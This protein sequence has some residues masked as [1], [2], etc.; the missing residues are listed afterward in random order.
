MLKA[1]IPPGIVNIIC[2]WYGKM[3][4]SVRWNNEL[5]DSFHVCSGV[6]QGSMLSP[7]LFNVFINI[8]IIKLKIS[9]MGCHIGDMFYGC[10]LYADDL[11]ILCPSVNGL[12]IMLDVCV[13]TANSLALKFNESKSHCIRFGKCCCA[14]IDPMLLGNVAIDWVQS[15][16]Y[17]GTCIVSGHKLSFDITGTKRSFYAAFN[18]IHSH[19]KSLDQIVQLTL[20]ESYCLPLLTYASAALTLS[21][22]QLNELNVCWNTVYRLI[23]KFHRWESVKCFICGLGRL[24]LIHIMQKIKVKFYHHLLTVTN[25][26]LYNLLWTYYSDSCCSD[27]V[28]HCLFLSRSAAIAECYKISV[29]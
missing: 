16:K 3:F 6:R 7:A 22:K 2:N 1:G 20:H 18:C 4:V 29:L 10:I 28:L 17:L 5:S 25:K 11:I 9:D 15:V 21:T 13:E 23:F 8:F 14:S 27:H 24:D 19:A 26:S 12:Q